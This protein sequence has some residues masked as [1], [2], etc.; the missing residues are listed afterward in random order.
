MQI[1]RKRFMIVQI[2]CGAPLRSAK[3]LVTSMVSWCSNGA[4]FDPIHLYM[5]VFND[6]QYGPSIHSTVAFPRR[7]VHGLRRCRACLGDS[8]VRDISANPVLS[9]LSCVCQTSS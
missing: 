9:L 7:L 2:S 4:I 8:L 5:I 3:V 6:V 1:L